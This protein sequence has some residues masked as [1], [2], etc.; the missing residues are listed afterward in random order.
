MLLEMVYIQMVMEATGISK[1]A[2]EGYGR[3][4]KVM[5]LYGS[6]WKT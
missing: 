3:G 6:L 1:K 4:W 2:M 5:E